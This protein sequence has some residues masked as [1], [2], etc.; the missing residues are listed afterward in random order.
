MKISSFNINGF[1]ARFPELKYW[2]S[3]EKPDIVG[4]QELKSDSSSFSKDM[5]ADLGYIGLFNGQK[6]YNGCGI[7]S[8]HKIIS[9]SFAL[10]GTENDG[11]S[12]WLSAEI[13]GLMICNLYLPNGNP[14]GTDKLDYKLKW[15]D[16]LIHH[17]RYLLKIGKPVIL[18][19]DFNVIP[20]EIDCL[21]PQK[22]VS[23]ALFH[24]KVRSKFFEI[25]NLGFYDALRLTARNCQV[26]TQWDYQG[27]AWQK[28]NGVR[29]DHFLLNPLAAD[30]LLSGGVDKYMRSRDRPSDHVPVWIELL[31]TGP[32]V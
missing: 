18:L 2:L 10:P 21:D 12:R 29:I 1:K 25:I 4:L 8:K 27:G 15:M 28:N 13:N 9:P 17:A 14:I 16:N 26:F 7:L 3:K 31:N 22:W 5:F 30:L 6:G 23:D 32:N 19:G 11:Q 24:P 20:Q